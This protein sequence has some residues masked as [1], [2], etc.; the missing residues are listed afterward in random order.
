MEKA[1]GRTQTLS[2][3]EMPCYF[4]LISSQ[5]VICSFKNH[6]AEEMEKET[7]VSRAFPRGQVLTL[8]RYGGGADDGAATAWG[9]AHR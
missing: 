5:S 7:N 6:I 2:C 8:H 1:T 4:N 9:G 3:P